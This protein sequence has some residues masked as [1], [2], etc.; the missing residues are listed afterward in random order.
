MKVT[1][2]LV[3]IGERF[4]FNGGTYLKKSTRTAELL[5]VGRTFYFSQTEDC[6]V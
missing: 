5:G 1:F 4:L 6:I 2:R 3:T